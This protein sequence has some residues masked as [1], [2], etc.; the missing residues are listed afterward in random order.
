MSYSSGVLPVTANISLEPRP[1]PNT[2]GENRFLTG[3]SSATRTAIFLSSVYVLFSKSEEDCNKAVG[4]PNIIL[5]IIF[6]R[7]QS[8]NHFNIAKLIVFKDEY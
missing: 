6:L 8:Y 2:R 7:F 3:A 1:A 4:K 5:Y